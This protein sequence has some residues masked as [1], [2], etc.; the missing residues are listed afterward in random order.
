[1][2]WFRKKKKDGHLPVLKFKD[3][4]AFIE[5]HC[6]FMSTDIVPGSPLAA[7]VLDARA[8][9]GTSVPV[10]VHEDGVQTAMLRVASDDG[11]FRVLAET[12]SA[13]GI[14][15]KPG[16]VVAWVPYQFMP[17][18]AEASDDERFG[19][20]GLIVAKIAPEIDENTQQMKVLS[21]Y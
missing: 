2:S 10:K 17:E 12:A 6:K 15:L 4:A 16:D 8:E 14:R 9:S 20:M 11:G 21:S 7:L 3:G 18:F 1:M 5:Y 13:N 19:W